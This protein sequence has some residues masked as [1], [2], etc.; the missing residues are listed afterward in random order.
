MSH[1]NI[2]KSLIKES[3]PEEVMMST[4]DI[5]QRDSKTLEKKKISAVA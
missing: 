2:F 4:C 3:W 5:S 1:V